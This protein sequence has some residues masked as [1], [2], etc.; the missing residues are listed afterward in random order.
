MQIK[1]DKLD[2][3]LNFEESIDVQI[4]NINEESL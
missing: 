3:I 1:P 2:K 4:S